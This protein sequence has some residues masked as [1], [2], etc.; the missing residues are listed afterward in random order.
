MYALDLFCGAGGVGLALRESGYL[1]TGIDHD[2]DA[3][4]IYRAAVGDAICADVRAMSP[5]DFDSPDL[6]WAS[7]PCPPWSEARRQLGLP[8]GLEHQDGDLLIVA[9]EWILALRPPCGI[10]ENVG[11]IPDAALAMLT[12]RLEQA[13]YTLTVLRLNARFWL[14]Q[15]R[16]HVFLVAA[17]HPIP[18]PVAPP[19]KHRFADIMDGHNAEP[20]QIQHLRYAIGKRAFSTP[21][22][23]ADDILPTVSTRPFSARWTCFV[24]DSPGYIRFPTFREAARAQGFPDDHPL[25]VLA[26]E[27]PA[28]AWR[29]LGNAVPV[30]L[31]AAVIRA[32]QSVQDSGGGPG[33][34]QPP[35][36]QR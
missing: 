12:D 28:V 17:S 10:I 3:V 29:L 22:I 24:M 7:P 27:K 26:K 1:V 32:V 31:A 5:A 18:I 36:S 8:W 11:G 6:L 4:E 14:P 33:Q 30:P 35:T 9:T 21:V 25:H 34:R 15:N 13:G 2:P 19:K 16:D 20:V 23:G